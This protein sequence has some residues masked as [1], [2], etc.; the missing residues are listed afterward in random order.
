[1]A[2]ADWI[3]RH[4]ALVGNSILGALIL[5][6][7][8]VASVA[9]GEDAPLNDRQRCEESSSSTELRFEDCKT[10]FPGQSGLSG[11]D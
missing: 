9:L 10:L 4:P 7:V 2:A 1:M 8:I 5:L 3:N 6:V 11:W